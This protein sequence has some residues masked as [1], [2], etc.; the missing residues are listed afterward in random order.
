M[1]G[2]LTYHTTSSVKSLA[3]KDLLLYEEVYFVIE[4]EEDGAKTTRNDYG[5]EEEVREIIYRPGRIR[6]ATDE[7]Q[8]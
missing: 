8:Q 2:K 7:E 5:D 1:L 6:R 3:K 4:R